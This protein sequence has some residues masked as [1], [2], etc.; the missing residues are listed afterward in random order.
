VVEQAMVS[1]IFQFV[2]M[3]ALGP[4]LYIITLFEQRF[5]HRI[6]KIL[7]L[8][9]TD[10]LFDISNGNDWIMISLIV[11]S[12]V[13]LSQSPPVGALV[14]QIGD[15]DIILEKLQGGRAHLE[16]TLDEFC[17]ILGVI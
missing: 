13:R 3:I 10:I 4:I 15:D 12:A 2:S 17:H 6:N 1:Y 7:D 8:V 14:L 9:K 16:N 5:S 11:A